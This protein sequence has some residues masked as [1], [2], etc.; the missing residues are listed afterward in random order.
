MMA[1]PFAV[2]SVEI[3]KRQIIFENLSTTTKMAFFPWD[4]GRGPTMST[5]MISHGACGVSF[6][7][8]GV[9]PAEVIVFTF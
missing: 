3:G 7:C 2:I 9:C 8:K 6:G 1:T 4:S 5:E